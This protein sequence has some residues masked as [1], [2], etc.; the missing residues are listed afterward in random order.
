MRTTA[1]AGSSLRQRLLTELGWV[2][3]LCWWWH[4]ERHTIRRHLQILQQMLRRTRKVQFPMLRRGLCRRGPTHT[5]AH[6]H[7][8]TTRRTRGAQ[9]KERPPS[10]T[11]TTLFFS[12]GGR[13]TC[14]SRHR[15][16]SSTVSSSWTR[17]F[18][19]RV[20]EMSSVSYCLR[21]CLRNCWHSASY[22]W[23]FA[24]PQTHQEPN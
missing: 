21:Y 11:G 20:K 7:A 6:A 19:L 16:A 1:N 8:R 22:G 3:G 23:Y 14:I 4:L 18:P 17:F 12:F 2:R 24:L 9:I 13:P 10:S 5:H 15:I